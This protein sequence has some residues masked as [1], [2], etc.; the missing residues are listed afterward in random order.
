MIVILKGHDVNVGVLRCVLHLPG[1]QVLVKDEV[2]LLVVVDYVQLA[3]AA[4]ILAA[5][6]PTA[7]PG[8][9]VCLA[10]FHPLVVLIVMAQFVTCCKS[11][12]AVAEWLEPGQEARRSCG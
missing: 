3:D 5:R 10:V 4:E 8:K 1:Q 7:I 9:E 2:S 12:K 6:A 11:I